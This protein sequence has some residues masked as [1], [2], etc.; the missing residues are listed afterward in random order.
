MQKTIE[1]TEQEKQRFELWIRENI[2]ADEVPNDEGNGRAL[3]F[4]VV[5]LIRGDGEKY[6]YK[7]EQDAEIDSWRGFESSE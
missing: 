4:N 2:T 7:P 6:D 5:H 3:V 1:L